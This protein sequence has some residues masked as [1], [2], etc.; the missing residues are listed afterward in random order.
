MTNVPGTG[1]RLLEVNYLKR[2]FAI[3][4]LQVRT[5]LNLENSNVP[6]NANIELSMVQDPV[7]AG[8]VGFTRNVSINGIL[9]CPQLS[10]A[11]FQYDLNV[12][13]VPGIY[14]MRLLMV[15]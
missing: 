3:S 15:Y 4:P 10:P 8:N 6:K 1:E 5:Y 7:F 13:K 12:I 9:N 2:I 14:I 11:P